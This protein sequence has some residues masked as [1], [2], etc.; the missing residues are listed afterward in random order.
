MTRSSS[1][2]HRFRKDVFKANVQTIDGRPKL[3]CYVCSYHIDP[4]TER[5]EADHVIPHAF[6]GKEGKPICKACHKAKTAQ[7]V[8]KI[9]KAKRTS[10][11]HY[12][13]RRKYNWAKRPFNRERAE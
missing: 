5:W 8:T 6:D 13:L 7:D 11:K 9:A 3:I 1:D 10:D 12:G 2:Q 4:A